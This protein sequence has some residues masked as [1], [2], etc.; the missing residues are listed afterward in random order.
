MRTPRR[1]GKLR[2]DSVQHALTSVTGVPLVW[3]I[4]QGHAPMRQ[5]TKR[6]WIA[7]VQQSHECQIER[8]RPEEQ[9][10]A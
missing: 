2:E 9:P 1:A 6:R 8:Q 10:T 4:A 3:C 7:F 5:H